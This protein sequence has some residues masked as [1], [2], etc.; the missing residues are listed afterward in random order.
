MSLPLPPRLATR[1]RVDALFLAHAAVAGVSGAVAVLLPHFFEAFFVPH[2]DETLAA[3]LRGARANTGDA[4]K[5]EHL[6]IRLYGCLILAQ[7]WIVA[8]ARRRGAGAEFR[9][10]L[11]Q[12]YAACFALTALSLLRAQL[13]P[14]GR[15]GFANWINILLF[16]GL[17]GGYGWFAL[18][19][20]IAAFEGLDHGV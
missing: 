15:L 17:A 7:A 14:G 6:I 9:R 2:D 13:T 19:E 18:V 11:V 10:A 4:S 12:A 5:I 20:K 1:R 3:L 16:A 8:A